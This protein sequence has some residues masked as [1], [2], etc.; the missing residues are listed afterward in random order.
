MM[1]RCQSKALRI[2]ANAL[3]YM[4][5]DNPGCAQ[6]NSNEWR[7]LPAQVRR[8]TKSAGGSFL[9]NDDDIHR[10]NRFTP[11]DTCQFDRLAR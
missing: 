2:V 5:N 8:P 7:M 6:G 9:D 11:L 3:W 4:H 1:Q 10:L